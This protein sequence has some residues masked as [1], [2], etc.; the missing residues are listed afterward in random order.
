MMRNAVLLLVCI[1]LGANSIA[2]TPGS[3]PDAPTKAELEEQNIRVETL[4]PAYKRYLDLVSS[5]PRPNRPGIGPS[6]PIEYM[7]QYIEGTKEMISFLQNSGVLSLAKEVDRLRDSV[8]DAS[9]EEKKIL[10][11]IRLLQ[12]QIESAESIKR[13]VLAKQQANDEPVDDDFWSGSDRVE[14]A[15]AGDFWSGE[16]VEPFDQNNDG[17]WEGA[18][19]G[20]NDK[21]EEDL[22]GKCFR[23]SRYNPSNGRTAFVEI[24]LYDNNQMIL[25]NWLEFDPHERRLLNESI[26]RGGWRVTEDGFI[27]L[28]REN[29]SYNGEV[30]FSNFVFRYENKAL[31]QFFVSVV[32]ETGQV[33]QEDD[34]KVVYEESEPRGPGKFYKAYPNPR[35][36]LW[37]PDFWEK[38]IEE[39]PYPLDLLDLM[40]EIKFK[41]KE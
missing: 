10:D 33:I 34:A 6:Q 7:D 41:D 39:R 29:T 15:A 1:L 18:D 30:K 38:E 32:T 11:R 27:Q 24:H 40:G 16:E 3:T 19:V 13:Q 25:Y 20:L 12:Q 35:D 23:F 4:G 14:N 9:D 17:F 28:Q 37:R 22:V 36:T 2:Q 5:E 31:R 26:D 8:G 21:A